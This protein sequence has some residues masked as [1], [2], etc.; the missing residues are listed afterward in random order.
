MEFRLP[1]G[2]ISP[3]VSAFSYPGLTTD[4]FYSTADW[5]VRAGTFPLDLFI[6]LPTFLTP[7][8]RYEDKERAHFVDPLFL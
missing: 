2:V 7:V 5:L 8:Y 3:R 4:K 6:P 1:C